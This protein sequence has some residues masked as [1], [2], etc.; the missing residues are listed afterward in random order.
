MSK[1]KDWVYDKSIESGRRGG[2]NG[3]C[4]DLANYLGVTQPAVTRMIN[5]S[6]QIQNKYAIKIMEFTGLSAEDIFPEW[7]EIFKVS[8]DIQVEIN[9]AQ[10]KEMD[11]LKAKL[12]DIIDSI[13]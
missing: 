1:L 9:M 10:K 12:Q 4:S 11:E 13:N 6:V 3:R 8:K 2:G 7:A 5:N